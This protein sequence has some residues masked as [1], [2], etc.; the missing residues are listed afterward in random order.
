MKKFLLAF[1]FSLS[2]LGFAIGV[3]PHSPLF[4]LADLYEE[5]LENEVVI[6]PQNPLTVSAL[7][8]RGVVDFLNHKKF[9]ISKFEG[10]S[11][12]VTVRMGGFLGLGWNDSPFSASTW[13]QEDLEAQ[14]VKITKNTTG[15]TG[16]GRPDRATCYN[17]DFDNEAKLYAYLWNHQRE[18]LEVSY[19]LSQVLPVFAESLMKNELENDLRVLSV[20]PLKIRFQ[21]MLTFKIQIMAQELGWDGAELIYN[22]RYKSYTLSLS[23]EQTVAFANTQDTSSLPQILGNLDSKQRSF[24]TSQAVEK[25]VQNQGPPPTPTPPPAPPSSLSPSAF[26]PY[27]TTHGLPTP[28]RVHEDSVS[29]WTKIVFD[30]DTDAASFFKHIM[31]ALPWN[32]LKDVYRHQINLK[33]PSLTLDTPQVKMALIELIQT[34]GQ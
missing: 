29:L 28:T 22:K 26:E 1:F 21:N 20:F 4:S 6:T 18:A 17:M 24:F 5:A 27:A 34:V 30:S 14:G 13:S 25:G 33:G 31:V 23:P 9:F 8:S 2:S 15:P 10:N 32:Q 12:K 3:L 11:G 16:V 7:A 19:N